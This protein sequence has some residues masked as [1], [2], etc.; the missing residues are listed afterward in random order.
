M[1]TKSKDRKKLKKE[2]RKRERDLTVYLWM[3]KHSC[4]KTSYTTPTGQ[5]NF[6]R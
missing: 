4:E 2:N 6:K 1:K 5:Q 3:L